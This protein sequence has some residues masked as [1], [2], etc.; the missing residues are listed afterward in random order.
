MENKIFYNGVNLV[1]AIL[2]NACSLDGLGLAGQAMV[3][4]NLV[5]PMIRFLSGLTKTV[6]YN[7]EMIDLDEY[8]LD[9]ED[10]VVP[11]ELA[12]MAIERE[13]T[14][15]RLIHERI[16]TPRTAMARVGNA[17]VVAVDSIEEMLNILKEEIESSDRGDA[18]KDAEFLLSN[19]LVGIYDI[20]SEEELGGL[21]PALYD[22]L[23]LGQEACEIALGKLDGRELDY[24]E[25]ELQREG[26]EA[27]EAVNE[28][29]DELLMDYPEYRDE[30]ADGDP[31]QDIWGDGPIF[32]FS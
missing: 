27:L 9:E 30:V 26:Y 29:L 13:R 10:F 19:A 16:E 24:E 3:L 1:R 32:P 28:R 14:M 18:A 8:K 20:W 21:H 2:A 5:D 4:D 31:K 25:L 11:A 15:N 12:M 6:P 22:L 17:M 7:G 23:K